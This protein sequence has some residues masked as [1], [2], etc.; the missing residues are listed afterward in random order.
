MRIEYLNKGAS[1]NVGE[2]SKIRFRLRNTK[3][4]KPNNNLD[5]VGVLVFLS[6]GIWQER[7]IARA[8]GDG[9]YEVSVNLPES[10]V[11]LVFV[12]SPSQRVVYRQ[13][14]YLTLQVK[15]SN[16]V[17]AQQHHPQ[18]R[19]GPANQSKSMSSISI[20]DVEVV[21]QDGRRVK[22][23]SDL[24]KGKVVA[25][26]FIFTTCTTIC[27]PL[28]ATFAR[29]Q[30]ELATRPAS[31]A[32]FI[33]ISVDPV[34]DTP[35]RLKAWRDKF[36]AAGEWT[37]ITGDKTKIDELLRALASSTARPEDHS[38]ILIIG[39]EAMGQWTRTYGLAK[40]GQII[41]I[42]DQAA[43]G[44]LASETKESNR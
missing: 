29:V 17:K 21:D 15:D 31:K 24:V 20:P 3:T 23:Y 16:P 33:S 5:D 13:L 9:V 26:N 34:T 6:P 4:N 1:F 8:V 30:K 38:P 2:E 37:L 35:E 42:I 27:P 36:N 41:Q 18:H 14:P 43:N 28:G 25:I 7:K 22:F 39:N 11:Y 10:G 44:Q 40:P 12:E 32:N 19:H